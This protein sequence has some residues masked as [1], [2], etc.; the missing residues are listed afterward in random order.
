MTT[1]TPAPSS[2][3]AATA[4]AARRASPPA[5]ERDP[6]EGAPALGG[7]NAGDE[8]RPAVEAGP[9]GAV[10]HRGGQR[11]REQAHDDRRD[12]PEREGHDDRRR[13]RSGKRRLDAG[14]ERLGNAPGAG[15]DPAGGVALAGGLLQVG[16]GADERFEATPER[17]RGDGD[18]DRER[19]RDAGGG[20]EPDR[21]EVRRE[22]GG[23][24]VAEEAAG[25]GD[26]AGHRSRVVGGTRHG[27][28]SP[29]YG[30]RVSPTTA[31]R[32]NRGV[33]DGS[34]GRTAPPCF[35][36]SVMRSIALNLWAARH[37]DLA[38]V[39]AVSVA[40]SLR[41]CARS[42]ALPTGSNGPPPYRRI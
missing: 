39:V 4:P 16:D 5:I 20:G 42:T 28:A 12:D 40:H 30:V 19:Q 2:T 27:L 22:D 21:E 41:S 7:P 32:S 15:T 34:T 10:R 8:R 26:R 31:T 1:S 6:E 36:V 37:G 9:D 38:A 25:R 18:A 29:A 14:R 23:G 33:A 3:T 35:A 13:D 11:T 24:A 17:E